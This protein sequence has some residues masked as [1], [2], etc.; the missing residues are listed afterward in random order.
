MTFID[1]MDYIFWQYYF[2]DEE[3]LINI[4][5][6]HDNSKSNKKSYG[7]TKESVKITIRKSSV[8]PKKIIIN[9]YQQAGEHSAIRSCSDF[10]RNCKQISN[11]RCAE[12]IQTLKDDITELIDCK[13][14]KKGSN[15]IRNICVAPG[16]IISLMINRKLNDIKGFC[17]SN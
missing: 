11:I 14:G 3:H 16:I 8:G 1:G 9:I 7:R 13:V 17:T 2:E 4:T 12:N 6:Q 5:K 10:P 15:F